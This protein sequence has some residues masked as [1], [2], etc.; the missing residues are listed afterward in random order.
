V[1]WPE[2]RKGFPYNVTWE[3]YEADYGKGAAA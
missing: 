3:E 1:S 2:T